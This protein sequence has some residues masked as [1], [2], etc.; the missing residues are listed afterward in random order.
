MQLG[1][2]RSA[3]ARSRLDAIIQVAGGNPLPWKLPAA[4][5]FRQL[6][7]V[8]ERQLAGAWRADARLLFGDKFGR[9]EEGGETIARLSPT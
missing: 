7:K 6:P 2:D 4:L 3:I 5:V 8:S 9:L 1:T